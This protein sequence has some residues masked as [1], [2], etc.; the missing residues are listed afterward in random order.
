M[1]KSILILT[2]LTIA[3]STNSAIARNVS[4]NE[5]KMAAACYMNNLG[6]GYKVDTSDLSI[7][8][9]IKN[10]QLDVPSCYFFNVADWGWVIM[11]ASTAT[12][13]IVAY[14]DN[15][16]TLNID[17]MPSNMMWWINGYAALIAGKQVEDSESALEE[18]KMWYELWGDSYSAPKNG[19]KDNITLLHERWGQG[20]NDGDT[21]NLLCPR[22]NNVPTIT[23]CVATA[24]S[25]IIH[26]YRFPVRGQG[27]W[28]YR[29]YNPKLNMTAPG[30][31]IKLT[32]DTMFFDY[33]LMPDIVTSATPFENRRE[34]ARLC[35][36]VGVAMSMT[37]GTIESGGSG[38]VSADVPNAMANNFKYN[39][40]THITRDAVGD[41]AFMAQIR[42]DLELNRPI[43]MS[44][45]SNTS[46]G[47]DD[48]HAWV[49]DGYK[50][51]SIKMYHMNWGWNN[52]GNGYYNLYDN[53]AS[54]MRIYDNSSYP[55]RDM[56]YTFT[57]EQSAMIGLI[58]PHP[59]SSDVDFMPNHAGIFNAS[60]PELLP[61]FPNP[62]CFSVTLPYSIQQAE[63]VT[64]YNIEGKVMEQHT[65]QPAADHI[66]I[67][68]TNMP[69]GIYIYRI[70]GAT[71][72]FLV[73]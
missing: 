4:G 54:G 52:K 70:G 38:A 17:E 47:R 15:G 9:Q 55:P 5:A 66:D 12:D 26:Y 32:F 49:C 10:P 36:A 14:G 28:A 20:G 61:A 23:G 29:W 51:N 37:Y 3:F 35:Y 71:S 27:N 13:P 53:T 16:L 33:S 67:N 2:I 30:K 6:N 40:C 11:S 62:A 45:T 24:L 1:K 21:Y 7:I 64:I 25:Q 58:P 68:V 8:Y 57:L 50:T 46:V 73:Q 72:K 56:G 60:T 63:T 18:N 42:G 44:G 31:L 65:L 39:R 43:Y 34:V 22:H 19:A 41:S 69:A 48:R 59:D